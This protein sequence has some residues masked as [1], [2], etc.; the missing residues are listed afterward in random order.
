MKA[1]INLKEEIMQ[2]INE[3]QTRADGVTKKFEDMFNKINKRIDEVS[4]Y[5]VDL[6]KDLEFKITDTNAQI[7]N[8][9]NKQI[10][11]NDDNNKKL[12]ETKE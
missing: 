7:K 11:D 9:L 1:E 2:I 6:K 8:N 3:R 4:I 12:L 10:K 5:I